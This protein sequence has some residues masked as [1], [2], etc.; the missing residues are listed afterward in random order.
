MKSHV[1]V[2]GT[3]LSHDGSA[4]LLRDGSIAVAVEKERITRR[5][6]DGGNDNAAIQY[7][8]DAEG[9]E[10]SDVALVV[11]NENFGMFHGGNTWYGEAPRIIADHPRVVSVS[12]HLAHAYSA[13]Y[14]SPF[15]EAAVMVIDGCGNS[16]ADTM[17]PG[18]P[19][20]P[21]D[22]AAVPPD[23]AHLY[24]EKDSYYVFKDDGNGPAANKSSCSA[25]YK[26]YSV[27]GHRAR[28]VVI[29]PSTTMHS[30]G[31]LYSA[32]SSYVFGGME[33]PGKLMGLAPY[34]RPDVFSFEMFE[35]REGRVFV[36]YDWMKDFDWP[37]RGPRA[38]VD[39][40]KFFAN[41]AWH[42]QR[43]VERALLY[44]LNARF[45]RF[46]ADNLAYAGGVA[47][48]AV[49]NRRIVRETR[50]RNIFFQPAAGDN[51]LALGCAYYGHR[52][53]LR[54]KRVKSS[55]SSCF[56]RSYPDI[57]MR[58]AIE[59]AAKTGG[60]DAYEAVASEDIL[61]R[62]ADALAAGKTVAWFQ[63]GS[64]F[65]PRALGHRSILA[66][67]RVP[68]MRDHINA[69]IKF[70]ED[71]RPF[72]PSVRREDVDTYFECDDESP[73]M[74]LVAPTRE[75]W[76]ERIPSVVH[77]DG[78][79]RIQ[80][81]TA[82]SDPMYYALLAAF[83][84]RSG[85]GIL[86]NTSFNRKGMPIVETPQQAVE[87]FLSCALDVLVLGRYFVEKATSPKA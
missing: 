47:L 57:E 35:L 83:R 23:L 13:F 68:E 82:A 26:D 42:T 1:Y 60:V 70:R 7:C 87:F 19:E 4:C 56:G 52:E 21:P 69:N 63:G 29:H 20:L 51:G 79:A 33:D 44:V 40:F 49:A 30:I 75:E 72:A 67:P 76:K 81:V 34:G 50:Y 28:G 32:V 48:N 62:T 2:L 86:L 64:E 27:W 22:I 6:H 12:H 77:R 25:L 73:Y 10:L 11:Q 71:F 9:I 14:A 16:L 59:G 36:R 78:S 53:I 39:N 55:G 45:E 84:E 54:E 58:T 80:T 15:D 37:T 85:V 8:L 65:G 31:G 43:E 74:I 38:F 66:D 61:A 3:G 5:K 24:N 41:L 17:D 18:S 46:P